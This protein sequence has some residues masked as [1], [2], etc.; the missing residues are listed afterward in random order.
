MKYRPLN[1]HEV[2]DEVEFKI[3]H[4]VGYYYQLYWRFKPQAVK[5]KFLFWEYERF[6][7]EQWLPVMVYRCPDVS[8]EFNIDNPY[9][10]YNWHV[11]T[12][13]LGDKHECDKYEDI[14]QEIKTYEQFT[15]RFKRDEY[16]ERSNRD[17]ERYNKLVDDFNKRINELKKL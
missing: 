4:H 11:Y 9:N 7:K 1:E 16:I 6:T 13:N 5:K 15:R 17:K 3:V 12:L 2:T 8:L 14:K 10:D